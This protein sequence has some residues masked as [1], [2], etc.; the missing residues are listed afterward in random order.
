MVGN[1][2]CVC[3]QADEEEVNALWAGLGFYR[4]CRLLCDG[5][6]AVVRDHGGTVPCTVPDLLRVPGIGEYTAG[7]IASIAYRQP[8]ALVDGNVVRVLSR[9]RLM[10]ADGKSRALAKR[11]W[12]LAGT[13]VHPEVGPCTPQCVTICDRG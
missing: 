7:A 9:T 13:L 2:P 12:E 4:R 8:V 6:R 10:A 5:A 11:C 1:C 3:R